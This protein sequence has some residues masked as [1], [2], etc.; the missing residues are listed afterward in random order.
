MET[1]RR[2]HHDSRVPWPL[3]RADARAYILALVLAA[4]T[5]EHPAALAQAS[6]HRQLIR[7][8]NAA[9]EQLL[10]ART[11]DKGILERSR[12][13]LDEGVKLPYNESTA[14]CWKVAW[15]AHGMA[16]SAVSLYEQK[17][18]RG[19]EDVSRQTRELIA[20]ANGC[21]GDEFNT[22]GP[23]DPPSRPPAG[24]VFETGGGPPPPPPAAPRRPP[25]PGLPAP[26]PPTSTPAPPR[27]SP[28]PAPPPRTPLSARVER[29]CD[30]QR[31]AAVVFERYGSARPVARWRVTN[32]AAPTYLVAL[33]GLEL[34][35]LGQ[36]KNTFGQLALAW[37][38]M[39]G[40][41]AYRV[42]LF[43]AVAD[44]P[45]GSNLIL[46]GHSQGGMEAQDVV[47]NLVERWGY[48]VPMVISY[49]API[50][51]DRHRGTAYLHVRAPD[52]PLVALDRRYNLSTN[53]IVHSN[54]G[55]GDWAAIHASYP[56]NASGLS[57]FRVPSV[58][59]LST[60]C[61]EIELTTVREYEAPDL[62][63]Q[64]FG[65]P[66]PRA[67]RTPLNPQAG[68]SG[69]GGG[70]HGNEDVNCFWVSLAQDRF[71]ATGIPV[72]AR[73]EVRAIKESEI[74]P[75]LVRRYGGHPLDDL[76]GPTPAAGRARH[77]AGEKVPSDRAH[78]EASLGIND[79][80]ANG[81]R[82]LVFV[83]QTGRSLGHVFNARNVGGRIQYWDEQGGYDSTFQL[84]PGQE[85]FFYRTN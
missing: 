62:F 77:A 53:E 69:T 13:L 84:A 81:R 57:A 67:V 63:T 20:Q 75:V 72:P 73:C 38:N 48:R 4:M 42:A 9:T 27:T 60:P 7:D 2:S 44:L 50:T 10:Q 49:G 34:D 16:T 30:L 37:S 52:E 17:H 40:F 64:F 14:D 25:P 47:T 33:A 68:L 82:G 24:D 22:S 74:P 11:L 5:V 83:R 61:Y 51:T 70:D 43:R 39:Q 59:V 6:R 36:G 46:V 55:T 45:A 19:Y 8:L 35:R 76:H 26:R 29:I 21:L 15:R 56:T 18:Y 54:R 32:A 71:W 41:D 66:S 80:N 85:I 65:P 31:L 12:Q 1:L 3:R 23:S 58:S 28:S 78:I 79:P